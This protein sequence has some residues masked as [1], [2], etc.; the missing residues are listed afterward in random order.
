MIGG[1]IES[2]QAGVSRGADPAVGCLDGPLP[3]R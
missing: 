1:E 2:L 3:E